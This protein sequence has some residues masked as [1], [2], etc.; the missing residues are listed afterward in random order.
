MT[1]KFPLRSVLVW[2][3]IVAGIG[4][5][6]GGVVQTGDGDWYQRLQKPGLNPPGFVF[7]IVWPIL[8]ILVGTAGG[9]VWA[10]AKGPLRSRAIFWYVVQLALN[11][12]W[13]FAFFAARSPLLGLIELVP[14]WLSITITGWLFWKTDRI[15]GLLF[16][17]YLAWVSFA[18]VLNGSIWV[19]N[20]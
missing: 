5:A 14:F 19:L 3:V 20:R 4:L 17:P 13:S 9:L 10:A 12:G 8:Y 11:F 6:I 18:A 15:A 7:G 16:I 1:E 2:I